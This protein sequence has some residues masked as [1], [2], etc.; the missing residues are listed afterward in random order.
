MLSGYWSC[1][2]ESYYYYKFIFNVLFSIK[3]QNLLSVVVISSFV[4]LCCSTFFAHFLISKGTADFPIFVIN[5]EKIY[6]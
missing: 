1:Y 3:V 4:F 6:F 2:S 5:E